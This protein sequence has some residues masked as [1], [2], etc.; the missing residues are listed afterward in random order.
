MY[1]YDRLALQDE[2]GTE[3]ACTTQSTN[4]QTD[5]SHER[6]GIHESAIREWASDDV[7]SSQTSSASVSDGEPRAEPACTTQPTKFKTDDPQERLGTHEPENREL[8]SEEIRSLQTSSAAVSGAELSG[9]MSPTITEDDSPSKPKRSA[10][11]SVYRRLGWLMVLA[12][13]GGTLGILG[14]LGFWSFLWFAD[15][16]NSTWYTIMAGDHIKVIVAITAEFTNQMVNA[17]LGAESSMLIALAL[18]RAEVLFPNLASAASSRK[19]TGSTKSITMS[20]KIVRGKWPRGMDIRL[21]LLILLITILKALT[22]GTHTVL[23]SDIRLD[24]LPLRPNSTK[25]YFGFSEIN[26]SNITVLGTPHVA[27]KRSPWLLKPAAYPAFAEYAEPPI[28]QDGVSDTGLTL[29]AFLPLAD[30]SHRQVVHSYS[31]RTTVL[32][33]RV[34]CQVPLI[35]HFEVL[36]NG[37]LQFAGAVGASRFTPRLGNE[38][39]V[40]TGTTNGADTWTENVPVPFICSVPVESNYYPGIPDRW[41]TSVCQLTETSFATGPGIAGG[42]VSEFKDYSTWL[43]NITSRT[44][45]YQYGSAYLVFNVSNGAAEEWINVLNPKREVAMLVDVP[46]GRPNGEWMTYSF[47][48]NLTFS[49]TICYTALDTADIAVSFESSIARNRTEPLP[50]FNS[51]T[52]SYKFEDIR[53][54]YGEEKI[55]N[56]GIPS[57]DDRGVFRLQN[58]SWIAPPDIQ[59]SGLSYIRQRCDL[60]YANGGTA[61]NDQPYSVSLVD[62]DVGMV[63]LNLTGISY[64]TGYLLVPDPMHISLFQEIVQGGGSIAFALQSLLTT[65]ASMTYYDQIAEFDNEAPVLQSNFRE[66][67]LPKAH[68][69]FIAV[70]T[71]LM[72]HMLVCWTVF[73]WFLVGTKF[74]LLGENWQALAQATTCETAKYIAMAGNMTDDEVKVKMKKDTSMV[75]K[76]ERPLTKSRVKLC[77][78]ENEK[79]GIYLV[80]KK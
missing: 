79:V 46:E 25:A 32:D 36:A 67:N 6:L 11:A 75:D 44:Q 64:V 55:Q 8:A 20:W 31:G 14:I 39:W 19:G 4:F 21:P 48:N 9:R 41:R 28:Q 69:G 49:T 18:E 22:I 38:T 16:A 52:A 71:A 12:I 15:S 58:Q 80:K 1:Q 76:L 26:Q 57:F 17:M 24:Q 29:R 3:P 72:V 45:A 65:V 37:I 56:Q 47:A 50:T 13:I 63:E 2:G 10:L 53:R 43:A 73:A 23:L 74:T 42:L 33:A 30:P 51:A 77:I 5:N 62:D 34:T 61:E 54:Q 66:T 60:G 40:E 59:L 70:A 35:D 7:R 27:A 68:W 78:G